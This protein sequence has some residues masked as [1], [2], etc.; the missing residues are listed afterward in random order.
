MHVQINQS[1]QDEEHALKKKLKHPIIFQID[2]KK[3]HLKCILL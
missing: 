1:Q 3:E 2:L